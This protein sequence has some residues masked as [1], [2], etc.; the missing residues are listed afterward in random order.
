MV[1]LIAL[2]LLLDKRPLKG[3]YCAIYIPS[4]N[5]MSS[6]LE[7]SDGS[8]GEGGGIS[9]EDD[10]L[11]YVL[12]GSDLRSACGKRHSDG[13]RSQRAHHETKRGNTVVL[14]VDAVNF[15]MLGRTVRS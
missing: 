6:E 9:R 10:A 4:G 12:G 1:G 5:T 11:Q 15:R 13:R 3:V 7:G 8:R 14:P 2:E